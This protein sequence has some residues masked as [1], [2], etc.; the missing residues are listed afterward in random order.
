M[1]GTRTFENDAKKAAF[2]A[3]YKAALSGKSLSQATVNKVYSDELKKKAKETTPK[4]SKNIPAGYK[5]RE[6]PAELPVGIKPMKIED[7]APVDNR[8][9]Q[10]KY[11]DAKKAYD[12]YMGSEEF[13]NNRK[14]ANSGNLLNAIQQLFSVAGGPTSDM[15][16]G[17]ASMPAPKEDTKE[18]ELSATVE[19]YRQQLDAEE[20]QRIMDA[21]LKELEGWSEEDRRNLDTF[22][23]QRSTHFANTLNPMLDTQ[24][25]S[26]VNNPVV[27]KYGIETVRRMAETR[28]RQKNEELVQKVTESASKQVDERPWLGGAT[29]SIASI[30]ANIV[31]SITSPLM[32]VAELGNRTGRYSTLDPNNAGNVP[33]VYAETVRSE[34][35]ENIRGDEENTNWLRKLAALGYQGGMSA[36]DSAAR[37]ALTGGNAS[38]SSALA[39][40]GAFGSGLRKYSQQGASPE[41]AAAMALTDAGLEY[42]TEKLPTEKVLDM[43]SKGNTKG[44][45]REVLKQA[46]LVEPASEEVNL[47][48]GVAA[49][50]MLLGEKSGMKQQM[51]EMI[52]NGMSYDEAKAQAYKG[53][54]KEA[55]QTYVVSAISG[56]LSSAGA[57]IAGNFINATAEELAKNA[58]APAPK[59]PLTENQQHL[60][61]A[62]AGILGVEQKAPQ[63]TSTN[64]DV[65]QPT[66]T[67]RVYRGYNQSNSPTERNLIAIF[68]DKDGWNNQLKAANPT[69]EK[70]SND[71]GTTKVKGTGAAEQNFSGKSQYQDLLYE[72]NVQPDRADDARAMEVPKT[73][74]QGGKVSESAANVYGSKYTPNDLASE[75]ESSIAR[76]ELSYVEITNE[77]AAELAT[78]KIEE[79]GSWAEAYRQ[80]HDEVRDG[81]TGAE[82][83]ARGAILLNRAAAD[84][85]QI[86]ATGNEA[87][88]REAK[89]TWLSVLLDVREVGT[90]TAQGLQAMRLIRNLAPPDKM[91][92][93]VATVRRMASNM[94]LQNDVQI[95]DALLNEYRMAETD[96]QRDEIMGKIQQNVADQIPSTLL[97]KWTALRYMNMLGNLKTNVRNI[98]GNVG[99]AVAYRMKDQ[100]AASVEDVIS[101]FNKNYQRTKTHTVSLAMLKSAEQDFEQIKT[102]VNSGG[103]YNDRMT[104]DSEFMQGVMD[105]RRIFKSEAKNETVRKI[106]DVIMAPAEG[107]RRATNWMMNNRFFGDEAFGRAAYS[108][109]LAGYL[110]A[111]GVKDT[112]LSKV[113]SE[114]MDK[115]RAYAIKEA[116]EATFHDNTALSKIVSKA[117]KGTG[118]VGQAIMPFTK[119]P[120]NVLVRAVEFS[121]LGI[122]D[123]AYKS[124]Q[125][126]AGRTKLTKKSGFAGNLAR[127]G[128]NITGADIVNSI[129][130]TV[131]G[132]GLFA[133]GALLWDQGFLSA[134]PSDDEE[135]KTLDELAG[136]Q[137]YSLRFKG[138]DGNAH[139]YTLEWLTPVAMPMFMGAEFWKMLQE[140]DGVSTFADY[141]NLFTAIADPMIQMSML[142]GLNDSLDSIRYAENN[143]GQFFINA[144]I[145]YLSQGLTNTLMGQVERTMEANRQTTYVDENGNLPKWAQR[146]LGKASQKIHGWDYQ[147]MDYRNEWG[148]TEANEGGWLYN[149]LSPG[150]ASTETADAVMQEL[151]RLKETQPEKV[152]PKAIPKKVSYDDTSGTTH[153]DYQLTEDQ[154]QALAEAQGQTAKQTL[155]DLIANENYNALTDEQKAK[156]INAAYEYAA[157]AGK[158]A[159]LPDY[160]SKAAA[161]MQSAEKDPAN[162]IINKVVTDELGNALDNVVGAWKDQKSDGEYVAELESTYQAYQAMSKQA[163]AAILKDASGRLAD[164]LAAR[165]VGVKSETFSE[166]YKEYWSISETNEKTS[167]KAQQWAYQLEKAKEAGKITE[168]QKSTLKDSVKFFQTMPAETEKFDQ[169]VDSGLNAKDTNT[170]VD[171]IGSLTPEYGKTQVS[172]IQ[173]WEAIVD[174]GLSKEST[175][176]AIK[177]YMTDYDPTDKSPDKTELKY[178]YI[179][180]EMGI[181][182]EVYN[183]I[184]RAYLE[185]KDLSSE[186]LDKMDTSR[187]EEYLRR[188]KREGMSSNQANE[189]YNLL[190]TSG[191]KKIDVVEWYNAQ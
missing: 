139:N 49:E 4:S 83:V 59:A 76:G 119:T 172:N 131:T 128:Q 78:K 135:E 7:A 1:A 132:T 34:V 120:A 173:K 91:D 165:K 124:A 167:E 74:L 95:D 22:I 11:D 65:G 97:D 125:A 37:I 149:L 166:L 61:N 144:A 55:A 178:D 31:G 184:Y 188:W 33:S 118:V 114:L 72:G 73:D 151:Y 89:Q 93:A 50:A 106:G 75:V 168:A 52:A 2:E 174:A 183:K 134:G 190:V 140:T 170:V 180:K 69:G 82:R 16:M 171:A 159:A 153:K 77:K 88:A 53:L 48:A 164:Y 87:A 10:Q 111:N 100:V 130:K 136:K 160:S 107:Y 189:L 54:W 102:L 39:G 96:S 79:A 40:S 108:R 109:A 146:S 169:L 38:V 14:E 113:D 63:Q 13:Q 41:Q 141:E 3:A 133:L 85:E 182:P 5:L 142:Q 32:Y 66:Q 47:F 71:S 191:K 117:Q 19:H 127:N 156:V 24:F 9:T 35:A 23:A 187:K 121:P 104:A 98:A 148:E 26:Y 29:G 12:T 25:D 157:E 163:K 46:F 137:P 64:A 18:K 70:Q 126:I 155:V 90:N 51:G 43:F 179:R 177:A 185:T 92:F 138:E 60:E 112:D 67:V 86:K 147:Q 57:N 28:E 123:T 105:K 80:W 56:G 36:A 175:D 152:T 181:D 62:V 58:P 145:N 30:P 6:D 84:Y 15:V 161:W 99:S 44:A 103:K 81:K 143:L 150:Y 21:D 17:S 101:L 122:L 115:A 68:T 186:E 129:A 116:Q 154:Y 94:G 8:T 27:K 110:K 162:T 45:V 42:I 20:N 158:K 176:A